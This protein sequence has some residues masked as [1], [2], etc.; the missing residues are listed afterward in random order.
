VNLCGSCDDGNPCTV[1]ACNRGK[2]SHAAG[3]DGATCAD[4]GDPCTKDLCASGQCTH[5]VGNDGA[6]CADDGNPCSSDVCK[7]GA[8]THPV[9]P[10]N[11]RCT[12]KNDAPK[13][14]HSGLCQI[15]VASCNCVD[16]F[17]SGEC[18]FYTGGTPGSNLGP[19]VAVVK[20]S[21]GNNFLSYSSMTSVTGDNC[22]GGC[23]TSGNDLICW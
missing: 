14:C 10:D 8:C 16:T 20:C 19:Q 7:Q 18:V 6:T 21:C 9:A 4:D 22:S 11:T 12:A 2:C 3:N 15:A 1:D 5:P 17:F 23:A 13:F